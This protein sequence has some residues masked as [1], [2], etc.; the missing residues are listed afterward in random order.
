MSPMHSG[1]LCWYPHSLPDLPSQMNDLS[2]V[3]ESGS[4]S[5]GSAPTKDSA[6]E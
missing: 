1:T 5:R 4:T 6:S 3:L 2:P